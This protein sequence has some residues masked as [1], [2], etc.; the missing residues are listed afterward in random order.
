[1]IPKI[2]IIEWR[3]YAPWHT[4]EQVEQDLI[5]SRILCEL[6]SEPTIA[7][8]LLFRG[9]TALHKLYFSIAGRYSEDIDLV[10]IHAQPIGKLI[11]TMRNRL[12]SW[13]GI[14]KQVEESLLCTTALISALIFL[15]NERLRSK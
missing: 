1:M 12:D 14:P 10:Q 15:L 6:Y 11:D 4:D 3:N 9:G 8:N 13:L 2:H 5:L 7:E